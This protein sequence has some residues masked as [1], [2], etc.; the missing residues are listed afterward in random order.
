MTS[1]LRRDVRI[2]HAPLYRGS[3]RMVLLASDRIVQ[4]RRPLIVATHFALIPLAY[5]LAFALRF[6]FDIPVREASLMWATLPLLVA[7]KMI[8][9][10]QLGLYRGY[11]K[12]VSL[13]DLMNL[14][15]AVTAS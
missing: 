9:F 10:R 14:S 6:D 15:I 5:Y 1:A 11:W 13:A 8:A 2:F 3:A 7:I 12:H 4:F